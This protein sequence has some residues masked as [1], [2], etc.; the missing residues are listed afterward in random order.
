MALISKHYFAMMGYMPYFLFLF[1]DS[2]SRFI[3]SSMLV[4]MATLQMNFSSYVNVL[5]I[6]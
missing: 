5:R 4:I 6:P 1:L 2:H 3:R